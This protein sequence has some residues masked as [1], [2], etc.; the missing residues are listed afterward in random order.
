MRNCVN[1]H[2]STCVDSQRLQG[3][4]APN[5]LRQLTQAIVRQPPAEVNT[6]HRGL[7]LVLLQAIRLQ[8]A[9]ACGLSG[10]CHAARVGTHSFVRLVRA[11]TPLGSTHRP[12][13]SSTLQRHIHHSKHVV[14]VSCLAYDT[15]VPLDTHS[16]LSVPSSSCLSPFHC[17]TGPCQSSGRLLL[18][19][20]SRSDTR[21]ACRVS[22]LPFFSDDLN[23][24][25]IVSEERTKI[26]E[27]R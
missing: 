14:C 9:A 12:Q 26:C 22:I 1:C 5:L 20:A 27:V 16:S 2:S 10:V 15:A 3:G 23:W 13:A 21:A 17:S 25:Q 24:Q 11:A 18:G 6:G 19:F 7:R 4:Q 8:P